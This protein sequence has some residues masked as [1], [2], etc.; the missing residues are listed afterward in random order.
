MKK[1]LIL[2]AILIATLLLSACNLNVNIGNSQAVIGSGNVITREIPVSDFDAVI[3]GGIGD[4]TITQG[5]TESL[6][7]E[8]E[9]NIFAVLESKVEGGQLV[10]DS[11]PNIS[12]TPNKRIRYTLVVKDLSKLELSGLGN[13]TLDGLTTDRL[14][15]NI[16]GSGDMKLRNVQAT[17]VRVNI[18][19]LGSVEISG[20]AGSLGLDLGG[21][22][23]CNAGDL[24]VRDAEIEISGLGSATVWAS[25][26]IS[27]TI[28]GS[29][30]LEYYGSPRISQDIS[31]LGSTHS[32]G[33]K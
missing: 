14:E 3:L 11:M 5:D 19:G 10:L 8:A 9:D 30:D 33:N 12:M 21:S 18:G 7:I 31:G 17:E 23:D 22:G 29:G 25:D 20:Q 16:S 26:Q 32:L 13:V 6:V 1:P 24:A 15:L 4:L 2:I 27:V 28:S